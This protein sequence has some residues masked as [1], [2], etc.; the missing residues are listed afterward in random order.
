MQIGG[1]HVVVAMMGMAMMIV[2]VRM[3]VL[4]DEGADQV[5]AKPD[6]RD[7]QRVAIR[8]LGGID[9]AGNGFGRDG[10]AGDAQ[11]DGAGKSGQVAELAGPETEAAVGGM[12]P[13]QP[14]GAGR[15]PQRA[16]MGRHMDAI[17][18]K[19]HG[20]I[21]KAGNDLHH[22]EQR[23]DQ[24]RQLG[25]GFRAV[26]G[27]TQK[28][29][30]TGPDAV[31]VRAMVPGMDVIVRHGTIVPSEALKTKLFPAIVTS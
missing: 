1:A 4:Q 14:I 22:H 31:T 9:Q 26:M 7:Q 30:A 23:G 2:I 11:H 12:T 5:D 16:D 20:V 6:H 15:Q 28:D 3:G 17:G 19:R 25:A 8:D 10:D 18:Q 24:G 27:V 13:R 29:M 21:E